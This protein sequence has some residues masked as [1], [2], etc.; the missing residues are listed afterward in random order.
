MRLLS[1]TEKSKV[2]TLPAII[3]T[4][5][6]II[7]ASKEE[8]KSDDL[9]SDISC[10]NTL[11][12]ANGKQILLSPEFVNALLETSNFTR[13]SDVTLPYATINKKIQDFDKI[14]SL[15]GFVS[16]L[17]PLK[18]SYKL[19]SNALSLLSGAVSN[20]HW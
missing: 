17:I 1:E 6:Q 3:S 14:N 10:N 19:A 20:S 15:L 8:A 7:R 16:S 4:D 5:D 9:E 12:F 13:E 18:G 2:A 11:R